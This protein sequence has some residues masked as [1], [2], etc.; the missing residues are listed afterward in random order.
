MESKKIKKKIKVKHPGVTC[1]SCGK[2]NLRGRRYKCLICSDYD[3]CE[4]CEEKSPHDHPMLRI[5]KKS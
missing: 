2:L 4:V 1:D 3:L 5:V